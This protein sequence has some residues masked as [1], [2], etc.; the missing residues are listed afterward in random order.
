MGKKSD[1][2]EVA[3]AQGRVD[4]VRQLLDSG[5][6]VDESGD[7]GKSPLM[8][9]V[10]Y[11]QLEVIDLLLDRG[12]DPNWRHLGERRGRRPL[13]EWEGRVL[14]E[15]VDSSLGRT[16]LIET[17]RSGRLDDQ[18]HSEVIR[19]LLKAGA[20]PN[21][22]DV[23]RQTP[24]M[25][26]AHE[27]KLQVVHLLLKSGAHV[28]ARDVYDYSALMHARES[29]QFMSKGSEVAQALRQAGADEAGWANVELIWAAVDADL[30]AV[31]KALE[32]GADVNFLDTS[33]DAALRHAV[34][35]WGEERARELIELLLD[36]GADPN[37]HRAYAKPPLF[38]AIDKKDPELVKL[39]LDHGAD[40]SLTYEEMT[41]LEYARGE[42]N[43]EIRALLK[44][45]GGRRRD[46]S[47]DR[48]LAV[49]DAELAAVLVRKGIDEVSAALED[50]GE[51]VRG[52][53]GRE[54]DPGTS[55]LLIYQLVGHSWTV[56]EAAGG[57][58][59]A[60]DLAEELSRSLGTASIWIG[61]S[62]S[63]GAFSYELFESGERA[64][65]F[66]VG[67]PRED[68]LEWDFGSR[69]KKKKPSKRAD[70]QEVVHKFL[71]SQDAFY[72]APQGGVAGRE[73][74]FFSGW[75][76]QEL[77]RADLVRIG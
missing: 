30:E 7:F 70:P 22:A 53:Q 26:A 8:Y 66:Y 24:L 68:D 72:M 34:I 2:L 45:A 35:C 28:N 1:D 46:L 47:K 60:S 61:A 33:G 67:P 12:A 18:A 19:R 51:I 6:S 58:E 25:H 56:L 32:Q 54:I 44:A 20:D 23:Q 14:Q 50:Q 31:Q 71:I 5:V 40:P 55:S 77:V 76:D 48:G 69:E 49:R 37:L 75:S 42:R 59:V 9:A 74:T 41:P 36:S 29:R 73:Q 15:E 11:G 64:E 17:I 10:L 39:L 4:A 52:V 65:W 27:E 38:Y 21:L 16:P 43:Q 62:D 57:A 13:E 3:A 63:A